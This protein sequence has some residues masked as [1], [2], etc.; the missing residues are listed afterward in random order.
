[1]L[2]HS[3]HTFKADGTVSILKSSQREQTLHRNCVPKLISSD[4]IDI[5]LQGSSLNVLH[6]LM[7]AS[8]ADKCDQAV[9][10]QQPVINKCNFLFKF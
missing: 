5:K 7:H 2:G 9:N 10:D 6:I 8:K 4:I 3:C 1:M